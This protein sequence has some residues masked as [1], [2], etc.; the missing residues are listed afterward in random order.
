MNR[1]VIIV[2]QIIMTGMMALCMSGIMLLI[3]FGPTTEALS[4]WPRNFL[5]A[6]PV[7]F[8][9]TNLVWPVANMITRRIVGASLA[10]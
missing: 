1:K 3:A 8:I 6:W 10:D 5:T 7:A 4:M 2:N 9:T